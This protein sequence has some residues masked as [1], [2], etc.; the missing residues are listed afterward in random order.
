MQRKISEATKSWA[1]SWLLL[2]F[3]A[4]PG[5]SRRF[6]AAPS[7]ISV[8]GE[9]VSRSRLARSASDEVFPDWH[10]GAPAGCFDGL[11]RF[12][13]FEMQCNGGACRTGNHRNGTEWRGGKLMS[14]L[15]AQAEPCRYL[16]QGTQRK[17]RLG[18][19]WGNV[20]VLRTKL[21]PYAGASQ[22][23]IWMVRAG[24]ICS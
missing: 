21:W 2:S 16:A 8:N 22:R 1:V 13:D 14:P 19:A 17:C 3:P 6:V 11:V 4:I 7:E 18:E 23:L 9:L 5:G 12:D 10:W 15:R 24:F 20:L